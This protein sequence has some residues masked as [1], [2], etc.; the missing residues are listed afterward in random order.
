M[1]RRR[2]T[3]P[4]CGKDYQHESSFKKHVAICDGKRLASLDF[5]KKKKRRT[6][7]LGDPAKL[8]NSGA[9]RVKQNT[10]ATSVTVDSKSS[11]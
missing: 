5:E 8:A 11:L 7:V 1:R 3:C 10:F 2:K 4:F 6:S 9:D